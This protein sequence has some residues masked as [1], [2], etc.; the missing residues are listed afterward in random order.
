MGKLTIDLPDEVIAAAR[1]RLGNDLHGYVRSAI[2][3]ALEPLEVNEEL[4]DLLDEGMRSAATPF[5]DHDLT[6]WLSI[7]D[8]AAQKRDRA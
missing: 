6:R 3:A 7:A 1:E 5:T 4:I 8:E 2:E